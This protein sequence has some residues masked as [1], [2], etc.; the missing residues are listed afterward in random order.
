MKDTSKQILE[1][2][3]KLIH[4][5]T[6]E[7][8]SI[9]GAEMIDSVYEMVKNQIIKQEPGLSKQEINAKLF[10]RLYQNDFTEQQKEKIVASIK[11]AQ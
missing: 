5:K 2:Q 9:M 4:S 7:E 3:R 6:E 8:R 11:N 1:M 10:L